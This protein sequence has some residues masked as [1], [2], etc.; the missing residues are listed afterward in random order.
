M[1]KS[2]VSKSIIPVLILLILLVGSGYLLSNLLFPKKTLPV[3]NPID[4]HPDLVDD[5]VASISKNHKIASFSVVNQNGD[6]I[7]EANYKNKIY[8]A[9]FFFTRCKTICLP[10]MA[11]MRDLQDVYLDD[12]TVK[13][14]SYSVT[15]VIDSIPILKTYAD[16]RGIVQEKW[17]ITT[18]NKKHIYNL[19][20]K[21]YFAVLDEGDGDLQDFIH[22]ERFILIDKKSQIRGF[23]DGTDTNEMKRLIADIK[24]L[25]REL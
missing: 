18:G 9:N 14:L 20:R 6:T 8:V 22:T 16:K 19:A 7:T 2:A 23:Y 1:G 10:M 11:N 24:I 15:P 17:N 25:K 5:T 4:V 13:F 3:F 21:S 12:P